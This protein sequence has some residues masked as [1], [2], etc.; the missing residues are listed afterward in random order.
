MIDSI[1]I[2]GFR[3]IREGTLA[4]LTPLTILVGPNGCGKSSVLEAIALSAVKNAEEV[5]RRITDRNPERRL[6]WMFWKKGG[7]IEIEL[8]G[9][10]R[11]RK[12][13]SFKS[14]I[15]VS[16]GTVFCSQN[17][18]GNAPSFQQKW[19]LQHDGGKWVSYFQAGF[20]SPLLS[21][22]LI[23]WCAE[24][25]LLPTL[26]SRV[27]VAGR[28]KQVV[29]IIKQVVPGLDDLELLTDDSESLYLATS[30]DTHAVPVSLA[31]DGIAML[32]R[33]C[34]ELA[35]AEAETILID[36]PEAHQHPASLR[37][38]AKA[39][40]AALDQG[41]QLILATHSLE[42]IDLLVDECQNKQCMSL[43]RLGLDD[44][45]LVSSRFDGEDV[46][47]ARKEIEEDLR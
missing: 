14:R 43:F 16:G 10:D 24:H 25:I 21:D 29:Q 17:E 44:G 8:S 34:C 42:L 35:A 37:Q 45:E 1:R 20:A 15:E 6:Y 12:K 36:E 3:G 19:R 2:T 38:G 26:F 31:G 32:V 39:M 18:G 47:S 30:F 46:H 4:N 5:L 9:L 41:L 13:T 27:R 28:K 22:L 7:I 40:V 33:L 23:P 11:E